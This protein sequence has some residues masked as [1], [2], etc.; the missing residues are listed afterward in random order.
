V[1][2]GFGHD[3]ELQAAWAV[4]TADPRILRN[5]TQDAVRRRE[6]SKSASTCPQP[7]CAHALLPKNV[8]RATSLTKGVH[9]A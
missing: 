9:P 4:A 2:G 3:S 8:S 5:V 6:L 7:G 1:K